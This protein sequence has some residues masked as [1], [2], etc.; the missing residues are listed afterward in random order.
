M[1]SMT[2]RYDHSIDPKGR[3]FLPS[4]LRAELGNPVYLAVGTDFCLDIYPQA[5]WD[6]L[7][8]KVAALPSSQVAMMDV[9]FANASKCEPD[10]QWRILIPQTLRDYAGLKEDVVITGNGPKAKI[11]SRE[12]WEEKEAKELNPANVANIMASLGI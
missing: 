8:E 1:G 10:S 5:A 6:A 2:G 7:A 4:K 12:R 9:F 3:L 11:W